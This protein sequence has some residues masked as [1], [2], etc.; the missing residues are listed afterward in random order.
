MDNKFEIAKITEDLRKSDF[1]L[2]CRLPMGYTC[3]Y[4]TLKIENDTLCLV[5]PFLRYKVTG[6]VDKTLV[7]PIRYIVTL[8]LP[9]LSI[10][11]FE[12]LSLNPSFAKVNFNKPIGFFRHESVKQ[13][14]KKEYFEKKQEL[15]DL[16]DKM[17]GAI[18]YGSEYTAEDDSLFYQL[19]NI[20]L[21]PSLR[22]IYKAID[23][24]FYNKYLSTEQ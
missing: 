17:A 21:E 6:Q 3:G 23:F 18:L 12:D 4:P 15:F 1:I 10:A 22:P 8:T 2:N 24:D 7:F 16:Y 11:G 9:E 20:L 14:S 19:L 13:Y 5:V